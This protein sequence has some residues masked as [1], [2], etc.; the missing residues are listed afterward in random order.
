MAGAAVALDLGAIAHFAALMGTQQ[1][2]PH[3]GFALPPQF[4]RIAA[5]QDA[6]AAVRWQGGERHT[7]GG[8][9]GRFT[10]APAR[11]NSEA[12]GPGKTEKTRESLPACCQHS[13][14]RGWWLW[15]A[16]ARIIAF[17]R[18]ATAARPGGRGGGPA[19]VGPPSAAGSK[20]PPRCRASS[21]A[22]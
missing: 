21:P 1:R 7:R 16:H 6:Q 20:L 5:M 13:P 4:D 19:G 9:T 22:Q 11:L 18:V 12:G 15:V 10:R 8:R 2:P 3:D 17:G 14:A